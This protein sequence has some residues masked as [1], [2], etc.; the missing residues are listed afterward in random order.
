MDVNDRVFERVFHARRNLALFLRK[1]LPPGPADTLKTWE[2]RIIGPPSLSMILSDLEGLPQASLPDG[3]LFRAMVPGSET[4]YVRVMQ[5]TL[6]ANADMAWFR[7]TFQDDPAYDPDNLVLILN[8]N[9]PVAAGA[10]WHAEGR[11]QG[12]GLVHMIG[13]VQEHR[14]HGVGRALVLWVLER[15][16]A[17]GF[18][19]ALLQTEDFRVPAIR[20]YLSLGFRPVFVH[21]THRLRWKR[22]MGK[23]SH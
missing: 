8:E 16:K 22:I 6:I 19:Q 4:D 20:L 10:A 18:D 17:R 12:V 9:G 15:L 5:R 3:Y 11:Q 13:V 21:R 1:V 7:R 14:A 23:V 2:S